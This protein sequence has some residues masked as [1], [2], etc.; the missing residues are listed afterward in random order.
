[1]EPRQELPQ[2]SVSGERERMLGL[3][4]EYLKG[5]AVCAEDV[6]AVARIF[7]RYVIFDELCRSDSP[8]EGTAHKSSEANSCASS[9]LPKGEVR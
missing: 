3:A 8:T 7:E 1:M 5:Y 4:V 2:W 6:V 9:P